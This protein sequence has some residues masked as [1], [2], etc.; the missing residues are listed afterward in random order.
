MEHGTA[1]R[2]GTIWLALCAVL[3]FGSPCVAQLPPTEIDS[4]QAQRPN[5]LPAVSRAKPAGS[6]HSCN[7]TI[8]ERRQ[9]L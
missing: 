4:D 2:L 3:L 5:S 6:A 8:P 9:A 7:S 1:L